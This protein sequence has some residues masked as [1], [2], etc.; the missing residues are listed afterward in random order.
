[1]KLFDKVDLE[2]GA[3]PHPEFKGDIF[4][5][6]SAAVASSFCGEAYL[7]FNYGK[8]AGIKRWIVDGLPDAK[9]FNRVSVTKPV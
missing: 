4:M 1:M 7:A 2:F 5:G 3:Y 9:E 6:I 8:F